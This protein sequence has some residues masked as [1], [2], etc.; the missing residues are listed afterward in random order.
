MKTSRKLLKT[1]RNFRNTPLQA[2]IPLLADKQQHVR[3]NVSPTMFLSFSKTSTERD[4]G[5]LWTRRFFNTLKVWRTGPY[6]F[7]FGDSKQAFDA[8]PG[9]SLSSCCSR[10]VWLSITITSYEW[11]IACRVSFWSGRFTHIFTILP[12]F[13][14]HYEGRNPPCGRSHSVLFNR[15]QPLSGGIPLQASHQVT[16]F[17]PP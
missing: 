1:V 5:I 13:G 3:S 10:S 9:A 4:S 11:I 16:F 14:E 6:R 12:A 8:S 2:A 17:V 15:V 7:T